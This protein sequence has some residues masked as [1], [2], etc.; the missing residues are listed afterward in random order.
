MPWF[1][2]VGVVTLCA[3]PAAWLAY[4]ALA[5]GLGAN[6]IDAITDTTGTWA[7]RFLV[8]TLA[9]TP[10][11]RVTGW[12]RAIAFRRTLGL[13]AFFYGSLH[14]ATYVVLDHF[15]DAAAIFEDV[16]KRPF[17][18]AGAIAFSLMVPLAVTSTAGWIRR[19]GG[20]AWQRLH[21]LVYLSAIAGVVH[22]YWLV[23]ADTTR[24]LRYAAV[25]AVL[26]GARLAWSW[27]KRI[28]GR[29]ASPDTTGA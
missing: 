26:L 21:R 17:V 7:L 5:G 27:R 9:V 6:P 10:L 19:L 25:L 11:R 23:K 1:V 12:N 8:A 24:P 18:L 28:S 15:F 2:R 14:V 22:Y 29:A 20:R 13:W 4:Q 3:L 16:I